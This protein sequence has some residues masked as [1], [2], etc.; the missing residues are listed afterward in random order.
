MVYLI[1]IY[2]NSLKKTDDDFNIYL[3]IIYLCLN[4]S[5]L[6]ENFSAIYTIKK[7]T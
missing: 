3:N 7:L 2:V 4:L 5:K 6:L 1:L